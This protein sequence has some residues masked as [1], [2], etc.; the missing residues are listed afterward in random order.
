MGLFWAASTGPDPDRFQLGIG[1]AESNLAIGLVRLG[2]EATWIGR[3]GNDGAGALVQRALAA[4]GVDARVIVDPTA[5]TGLM[6]KIQ[7]IA[8]PRRVDYYRSAS[9]GS[10]LNPE[11]IDAT[12]IGAAAIVHVTGITP[13]LSASAALAIDHL[14]DLANGAGVPVSFDVNHRAKIW[15]D[16]DAAETYRAIASR[17]TIVFAGLDE[18]AMLAPGSTAS[19]LAANISKLGPTQVLVKLEADGCLANI[20]GETMSVGAVPITV[21]DTVGAGDAFAA[22]YLAELVEGRDARTRLLTAVRAGAFACLGPGDWE[23]LPHRADL[24]L[25]D[26]DEPVVR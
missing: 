9:A 10:R 12:L 13:G 11:D 8:G 6:V 4:E 21:V 19:E 2:I 14:L 15:R 5:P 3:V 17:S 16:R 1:G 7:S 25:L 18:A 22:G 23:S 20:D 26:G 24:A